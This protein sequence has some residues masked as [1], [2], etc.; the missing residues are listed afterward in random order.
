MSWP[1][2]SKEFRLIDDEIETFIRDIVDKVREALKY[3]SKINVL[4][5]TNTEL[6]AFVI[7]DNSIVI[8][9][10]AILQCNN[11][12]EFIA[13]IAHE[14]G[15]IVGGH[16][17]SYLASIPEFESAG[18]I[19]MLLGAAA[20]IC[21]RNSA[22]L[23]AGISGG[24]SMAMHMAAGKIRQN[25]AI[26]DTNAIQAVKQLRWNVIDG[27]ISLHEKINKDSMIHN[28]YLATHPL[29]E[30]R[31]I[32]LKQEY[33]KERNKK[34]PKSKTILIEDMQNKFEII[35]LKAE[36]L[37]RSP[38]LI[39][40]AYRSFKSERYIY[41]T[42]IALHRMG[43][44]NEVQ[45][46]LNDLMT[47]SSEPY[48]DPAHCAEILAMS[49]I[50]LKK[51]SEAI[52]LCWK[53]IEK[54]KLAKYKDLRII[55][56]NAVIEGNLNKQNITR[57]IRVIIR[58]LKDKNYS[59]IWLLLGKLYDLNENPDKASLCA[60]E[61]ALTNYDKENAMYHAKKVLNSKDNI[62]KQRAQDI[63]NIYE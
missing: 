13:I 55:Y 30:N 21:A 54:D 52:K 33:Q 34:F 44:H 39:I 14:V 1:V 36:S 20:S 63:I 58:I 25:E 41:V 7:Q 57:A 48:I 28:K 11:V 4:V 45:T 56:A 51:F 60:A 8:N 6:N 40:E 9:A 59:E 16:I 10:G 3:E 43:K 24:Q 27:F 62:C 61:A 15:H 5:S 49:L 2:V 46:I 26:A 19:A 53:F 12:K 18:I 37:I 32:K 23:M 38:Q 35:K 17:N 31:I 29:S 22:P 50:N 42:A 47:K